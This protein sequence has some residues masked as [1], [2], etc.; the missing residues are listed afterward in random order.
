MHDDAQPIWRRGPTSHEL[1][2]CKVFLL[3]A[4]LAFLAGSITSYSPVSFTTRANHK[5]YILL[6]ETTSRI[7]NLRTRVARN[8]RE[9]VF[10]LYARMIRDDYR[11]P[12]LHVP[13][14]HRAPADLH[15]PRRLRV[16]GH[17]GGLG[18]RFSCPCA[19]IS[20]LK[21]LMSSIFTVFHWLYTRGLVCL[22]QI[23]MH[24]H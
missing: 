24:G 8:D 22:Y 6:R 1:Q 21:S 2:A 16:E 4:T 20:Y 15:L 14:F 12:S 9:G 18:R 3:S 23:H 7:T 11:I 13:S 5:L 10:N 19:Y 17:G